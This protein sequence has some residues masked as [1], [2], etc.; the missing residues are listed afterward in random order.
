L[1]RELPGALVRWPTN[2]FR[3]LLGLFIL[4]PWPLL[5]LSVWGLVR[6][7]GVESVPLLLLFVLPLFG[8]TLQPRFAL[9]ALPALGIAAVAV[10]ARPAPR[11]ARALALVLAAF[12]TAACAWAN[13]DIFRVPFDGVLDDAERA[14]HWLA[15]ASRPNEPVIDRKPFVAFYADRP[16]VALP[17]VPYDSIVGGAVRA[18]AGW[19]VVEQALAESMRRQ[20]LPLLYDDAFRAR[21]TRLE[22]RYVGGRTVGYRIGIFRVLQ[23]GEPRSRRPI[24]LDVGEA[25]PTP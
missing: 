6:R 24:T 22:L 14:G 15:G 17:D 3:Q 16:F 12:G 11:W 4:W 21:E 13:F 7:R 25:A 9:S 10:F 18:R 2:A 19:L 5:A 20:L 23:P 1:A 8:L